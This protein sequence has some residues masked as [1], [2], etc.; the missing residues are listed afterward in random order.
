M[1]GESMSPQVPFPLLPS[2]SRSAAISSALG[3]QPR[4]IVMS[5]EAKSPQVPFS[6][7]PS[8]SPSPAISMA[9]GHHPEAS[10]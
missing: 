10:L 9:L 8:V 4:S 5:G 1:S 2:F 6:L 7:L 3:H